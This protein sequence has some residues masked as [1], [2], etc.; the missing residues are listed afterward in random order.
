MPEFDTRNQRES[1]LPN[2]LLISASALPGRIANHPWVRS[3]VEGHEPTPLPPRG[4]YPARWAPNNARGTP[5][6]PL[7]GSFRPGGAQI[8]CAN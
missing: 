4:R 7:V 5:D 1:H 6:N 2:R 3:A 8:P